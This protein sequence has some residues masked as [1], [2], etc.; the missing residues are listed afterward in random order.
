MSAE[1]G[2]D[3][4]AKGML[5]PGL[6]PLV[7]RRGGLK[8]ISCMGGVLKRATGFSALRIATGGALGIATLGALRI[9]AEGALGT[10]TLGTL[11]TATLVLVALGLA[12]LGALRTA[13]FVETGASRGCLR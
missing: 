11:R 3:H 7:R 5:G 6:L 12:S 8:G 4:L 13:T 10:A 9:T 1:V 2:M